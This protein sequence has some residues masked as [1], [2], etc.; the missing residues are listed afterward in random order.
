MSFESEH[1]IISE[2]PRWIRIAQPY[3]YVL[4]RLSCYFAARDVQAQWKNLK[5]TYV[6]LNRKARESGANGRCAT[7]PWRFMTAMRFLDDAS[8]ST[9]AKIEEPDEDE[10]EGEEDV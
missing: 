6:R 5:D 8:A 2:T 10:E 1:L 3:F 4:V 9:S 7:P